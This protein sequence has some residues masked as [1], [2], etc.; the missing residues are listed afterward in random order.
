MMWCNEV[1]TLGFVVVISSSMW[2]TVSGVLPPPLPTVCVLD[3]PL[4]CFTDSFRRTFPTLVSSAKNMTLETCA[5]AC[6]TST[7][8]GSPFSVAAVEVG[9]QCFCTNEAGLATA[10]PNQTSMSQCMQLSPVGN[11]TRCG[12][13]PWQMCG[14]AWR[15]MAYNFTCSKY[16]PDNEPWR[17]P[18][19]D[20]TVRVD[21]LI[22]RMTP[23]QLIAQLT[24][25]GADI[26]TPTLQLP[27]YIV[28]QECLA[29]FDGGSIF[30]A[31]DVPTTP[32]S[33]FPQP[34]NMG[35]TW[36]VD[37]VRELGAAISDEARAAW[38]Y[39]A[40]PSLTCMS[41]NLNLNRDPRWGRNIESFTED[42]SL[43]SGLGA[44][45]IRGIQEG[46]NSTE[47][48]VKAKSGYL[49]MM[50]VPKH[51]GAY[52]VECFNPNGGANDYPNCPVYRSNFNAVVDEIDL[53][54]GY[55]PGWRQAV[56]GSNAQGVM[57]SYNEIN[58]VPSCLNG[59][60]IRD[61]LENE[62]N[63]TGFVISDADAVSEASD[64]SSKPPGHS[65]THGIESAAIGALINGTTI[66]LETT[67]RGAYTIHLPEALA[68]GKVTMEELKAAARRALLPRFR[69]GLYDPL[70]AV[71]WNE[72]PESVIESQDHHELARRAAA[73]SFVLLKN[74]HGALP[75]RSDGPKVVAVVGSLAKDTK[76][77][78]NRYSGHPKS[79]TSVW[80]GISTAAAAAGGSAIL[81]ASSDPAQAAA[82]VAKADAVVLVLNG[83]R[84]GESHDR[85]ILNFPDDQQTLLSAVAKS[86]GDKDLIV[87]LISGGAIDSSSALDVADAVIAMYSGGMEAG[88]AI[89][90]VLY[91]S[92]NPSGTL[93]ATVYRQSWT[94]AS[95]FL[96]MALRAP[97]G[98]GHRYLT[99]SATTNHVLFP[100]GFG[101]SYSTWE[102]SIFSVSPNTVSKAAILSGQTVTVQVEVSN[103]GGPMGSRVTYI[104]LSRENAVAEEEWPAQWLPVQG[105]AKVH[106][107]N[108]STSMK[109]DV[110]IGATDVSRWNQHQSEFQV[111]PGTYS[112]RVRDDIRS[113]SQTLTI[114]P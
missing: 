13:N 46:Q 52:S 104:L 82:V 20:I 86:A 61:V 88:S 41:P 91:G 7:L 40:R 99:E 57:C 83:Y 37:L 110:K 25:N 33:G 74:A 68:E 109:I 47:D 90:D 2:T 97:P 39:R 9:N 78:I 14:G 36:D 95:D 94:N 32:S 54:E 75:F 79:A 3:Q 111:A 42:P 65:F 34:V 60:V 112:V 93:A 100:F 73:E 31:P 67:D 44:A 107:V 48:T 27:R 15:L 80:D 98:R 85:Q 4:G 45:Y 26:Y 62:W 53:R 50:A 10:A 1:L 6:F 113:Q 11:S 76:A 87:L 56:Q 84:E 66:S 35:N 105:F 58:G 19:E 5:T 96:S 29:G 103:T 18:T 17:D 8:P 30:I 22:S 59:E 64:E 23:N 28:S 55:F 106:G 16:N 63:L 49:K 38:L 77:S 92:V 21:D 12:G 114:T 101:L 51:L 108:A 70:D 72:I 71:P 81:S 69:V 89:A 102:A 24:Q 43:L